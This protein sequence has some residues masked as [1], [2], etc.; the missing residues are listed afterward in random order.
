MQ[1]WTCN[2]N[3]MGKTQGKHVGERQTDEVKNS[4]KPPKDNF[5]NCGT[6]WI[7][8]TQFNLESFVTQ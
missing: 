4:E 1:E 8:I 7:V 2:R 3:L 6:D 5:V